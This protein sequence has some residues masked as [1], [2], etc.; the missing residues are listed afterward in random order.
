MLSKLY[1][2][3][4]PADLRSYY[5]LN[6]TIISVNPILIS[7][8]ERLFSLSLLFLNCCCSVIVFA[9]NKFKF[10]KKKEICNDKQRTEMLSYVKLYNQE[11][12]FWLATMAMTMMMM[13]MVVEIMLMVMMMTTMKL[14]FFETIN[15]VDDWHQIIILLV[16]CVVDLFSL[17]NG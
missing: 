9:E 13:M 16:K 14:K 1:L 2:E 4:R 3:H 7:S 17:K 5:Y 15:F 8:N 10:K 6:S 11:K 12:S